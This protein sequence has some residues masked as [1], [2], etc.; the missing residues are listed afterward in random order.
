[1]QNPKKH[2]RSIW[3]GF[4]LGALLSVGVFSII[5]KNLSKDPEGPSPAFVGGQSAII[6]EDMSLGFQF[7]P[8]PSVSLK[9][10][11]VDELA[12]QLGFSDGQ[13]ALKA[14]STLAERIKGGF[15]PGDWNARCPKENDPLLCSIVDDYLGPKMMDS[16]AS[17]SRRGLKRR[18]STFVSKNITAL[19]N[20]D[21]N[22]QLRRA[23]DWSLAQI[24]KLALVALKY[25]DCPRNF[26]LTLARELE[27]HL[28]KSEAFSLMDQLDTHG[29]QCVKNEDGWAETVLLRVATLKLSRQLWDDAIPLLEKAM[30]SATRKEEFRTLFW[31]SEARLKAGLKKESDGA[32]QVL[33]K[34]YPLGWHT[35]ISRIEDGQDPLAGIK[36]K[37]LYSDDY[38][39]GDAT[40]DRRSTWL[41]LL[42]ALDD[43]PFV[44]RHYGEFVVK[45]FPPNVKP[46]FVQHLARLFSR[47]AFYRLQILALSQ[48]IYT[49]PD[50]VT[51]ETL[52]LLYPRPY[53]E[54]LQL[55]S[56]F[57]TA[58]LLGL[59]RQESGFDPSATSRAN[60]QGIMQLLPKTA[61]SLKKSKGKKLYDYSDNIAL[62][63]QYLLKLS[64]NFN[65][66]IEK[67]LASYNAGQT[68]VGK[69][70]ARFDFV[71]DP[72][73]FV[74]MIPYRETREYV[75]SILRN[76]Y[77]YHRLFPELTK[78]LDAE[79]TTSSILKTLLKVNLPGGGSPKPASLGVSV[80]EPL[81]YG[82]MPAPSATPAS[83]EPNSIEL[84]PIDP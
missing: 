54:N 79:T 80:A 60:A 39:S 35:I 73:L 59:A 63:S 46:G 37:S 58:I 25:T 13:K 29:L 4:A 14:A 57:D 61:R 34:S 82:P 36:G 74:D 62:G 19:Q 26:S 42:M 16:Q 69:W 67:T 68:V 84:E 12:K 76:A 51:L 66:S 11:T 47:G 38:S 1:M 71:Q 48:M 56:K 72:Q 53:F 77:W 3:S 45:S 32:R 27:P 83:V 55:E 31:L 2:H 8:L 17:A 5:Y 10:L 44:V 9:P 40:L 33:W 22:S 52:R 70:Q 15:M 49:R 28:H 64:H 81:N 43:I 30:Q 65:G 75:S 23:P 21:F 7:D 18:V 41:Q 20:E 50:T 78:A 6:T 24:Q